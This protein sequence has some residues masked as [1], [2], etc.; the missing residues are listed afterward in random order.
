MAEALSVVSGGFAVVSLALQLLDAAQQLHNFWQSIEESGSDVERIKNH[1]TTLQAVAATIAET[2]Q[3]EPQIYYAEAVIRSLLTCKARIE[4]L[5]HLTRNIGADGR[6]G[7]WSKSWTGLRTTIKDKTIRK[8]EVQLNGDLMV[9]I[10]AL[11][12]FFQ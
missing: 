7:R 1:L 2:C 6:E 11:Q 4:K 9:L 5:T 12:P 3:Q 8:F 10:L